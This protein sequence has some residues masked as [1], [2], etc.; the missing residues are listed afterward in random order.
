MDFE[1][2]S[3]RARIKQFKQ[4]RWPYVIGHFGASGA[5]IGIAWSVADHGGLF[6][7]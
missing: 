6:W 2:E 3:K 7:L 1:T 4:D 5:V